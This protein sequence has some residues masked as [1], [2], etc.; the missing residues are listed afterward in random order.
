M[1]IV[2]FDPPQASSE[3]PAPVDV[4]RSDISDMSDG[5][6]SVVLI[7]WLL[8]FGCMTAIAVSSRTTGRSIW[9]LGPTVD[10]A[11]VFLVAVPIAIVVF[12]IWAAMKRPAAVRRSGIACSLLL[13]ASAIPDVSARPGVAVAVLTVAFAALLASVSVVLATRH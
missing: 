4:A 10:P 3:F 2:T 6:R 5:W 7:T 1:C 8:T 9:W 12:P 11:P 13:A